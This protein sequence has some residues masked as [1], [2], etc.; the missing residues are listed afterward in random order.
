MIVVRLTDGGVWI[1][2]PVEWTSEDMRA[3]ARIG[4]VRHLVSPTPL[5][6]W[7]INAWA[8]AFPDARIWLAKSLA[9]AAP[10]DWSSDLDQMVFRG[11]R[12]LNEVEFFHR[13][14]RTL[15]IGDF[16]QNYAPSANGMR[17]FIFKLAGVD[18]GTPID[19]RASFIG[20]KASGRASLDRL[21]SWDFDRL[22]VAHGECVDHDARAFARRA[23]AWLS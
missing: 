22:I 11:S 2:S 8:K 9:D 4:P 3:V 14:S 23:F 10:P 5:H 16:I 17:N 13:L 6:D 7:R 21:L 12:V 19:A 1:N 15:I 18:G 20:N